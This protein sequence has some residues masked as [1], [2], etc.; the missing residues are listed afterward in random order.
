MGT[1]QDVRDDVNCMAAYWER[2]KMEFLD[3]AASEFDRYVKPASWYERDPSPRS[4]MLVNGLFTE[5]V[6]FERPMEQGRTPL[7]LYIERRPAAMPQA[8]WARLAEVRD[9]QFFSRF[10]ICHKDLSTGMCILRDVRSGRRYDVFDEHLCSIDRW[11]DGTLAERI[12]CVEGE[13]RPVAQACLYDRAAPDDTAVD[14]P[15]EVHPEDEGKLP[16]AML[17]SYYLR[18]VRDTYGIDGRYLST[19]SFPVA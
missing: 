12:G 8:S 11:R 4:I 2:R 3:A 13:W 7:E 9:T 17:D 19:A 10:A 14:G 6:L 1:F 18:L 16:Q 15:G 5:W